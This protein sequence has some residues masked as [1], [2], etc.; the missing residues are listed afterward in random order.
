MKR[1]A[2]RHTSAS[3]LQVLRALKDV[4]IGLTFHWHF[5]QFRWSATGQGLMRSILKYGSN[6]STPSLRMGHFHH[7]FRYK[8]VSYV[9]VFPLIIPRHHFTIFTVRVV[10]MTKQCLSGWKQSAKSTQ[11]QCDWRKVNMINNR[12]W[13][14]ICGG[15]WRRCEL[16]TPLCTQHT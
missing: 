13:K 16:R 6:L 3:S 1:V 14:R 15:W 5:V 9:S 10:F 11:S 12:K 7:F 2:E 8:F 4:Q